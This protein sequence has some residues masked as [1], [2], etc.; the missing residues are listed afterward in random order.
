MTADGRQLLSLLME[1]HGQMWSIM[2][3]G[4][5]AVLGHSSLQLPPRKF[6]QDCSLI[7][8]TLLAFSGFVAS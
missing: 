2:M 5:C 6:E 7:D 8:L 1:G 3:L 4:P